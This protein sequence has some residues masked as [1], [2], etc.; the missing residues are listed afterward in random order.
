VQRF[1]AFVET[2]EP[3]RKI[4]NDKIETA[5]RAEARN[6]SVT[7]S[8]STFI[9]ILCASFPDPLRAQLRARNQR[10]SFLVDRCFPRTEIGGEKRLSQ[11]RILW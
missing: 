9:R 7:V 6:V 10:T 3:K 4:R 8:I 1:Q 11:N 5:Y 2:L